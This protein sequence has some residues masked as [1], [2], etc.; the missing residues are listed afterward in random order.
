[1][2]PFLVEETTVSKKAPIVR[3]ASALD[4]PA[5]SATASMSSALV[6]CWFPLDHDRSRAVW[7]M[8]LFL[9]RVHGKP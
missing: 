2:S 7:W 9:I 3:S 1:L 5:A 8:L 4:T 6:S